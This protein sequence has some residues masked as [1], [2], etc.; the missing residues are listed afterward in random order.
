MDEGD[1]EKKLKLL[2][3]LAKGAGNAQAKS[4]YKS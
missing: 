3:K 4:W 2:K 1:D